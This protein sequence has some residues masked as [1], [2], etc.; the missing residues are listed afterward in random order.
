[1]ESF[2]LVSM[3]LPGQKM[4]IDTSEIVAESERSHK[5]ANHRRS[6]RGPARD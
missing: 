6:I 1:M 4:W 3:G 5:V 2:S